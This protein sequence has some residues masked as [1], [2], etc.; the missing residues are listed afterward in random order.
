M[1][2]DPIDYHKEY[3]GS[4]PSPGEIRLALENPLKQSLNYNGFEIMFGGWR[5]SPNSF[6][7]V[8]LW[9]AALPDREGMWVA[10]TRGHVGF[11]PHKS[12]TIDTSDPRCRAPWGRALTPWS[13]DKPQAVALEA[14]NALLER[15]DGGDGESAT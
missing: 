5:T 4:R 9:V 7:T 2:I 11:Y 8:G 1:S 14:L 12:D 10:D 15:L 13:P 6:N 3:R